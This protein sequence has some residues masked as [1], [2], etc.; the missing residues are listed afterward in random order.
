MSTDATAPTNEY[1]PLSLRRIHVCS[2]SCRNAGVTAHVDASAAL[3]AANATPSKGKGREHAEDEL[4]DDDDDEDDEDDEE[5]EAEDGEEDYAEIDP[6][7]II[8]SG[9]RRTRGV[10]IDYT[11]PEALAKAGLKSDEADDDAAED[12]FVAHDDDMQED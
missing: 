8:A 2:D 10:K 3:E 11:S 5:A 12:S 4:M 6:S 9:T 1:V 7:A